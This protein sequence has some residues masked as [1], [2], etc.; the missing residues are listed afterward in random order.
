MT[1]VELFVHCDQHGCEAHDYVPLDQVR[2]AAVI[3]IESPYP[4]PP[5]WV[6]DE[7]GKELCV[8]HKPKEQSK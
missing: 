7:N 1:F 2:T 5:G 3:R 6:R 4:L 8:A